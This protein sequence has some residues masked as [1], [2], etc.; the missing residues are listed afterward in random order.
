MLRVFRQASP[1][2]APT[3]RTSSEPEYFSDAVYERAAKLLG[4]EIGVYEPGYR[5]PGLISSIALAFEAQS[6]FK[7]VQEGLAIVWQGYGVYAALAA[8]SSVR[9]RYLVNTYKVPFATDGGPGKLVNDWLL[10]QA[11]QRA[12]GAVAI[13]KSQATA[14][15][16]YCA[17]VLWLPF[18]ADLKWWSPGACDYSVL[19]EHGIP[20]RRFVV[21]VGDVDRDETTTFRALRP[22]RHPIVRVTRD[23]AT[24]RRAQEVIDCLGVERAK[25]VLGVPLW[26]LREIYR[27]AALMVV[28]ARSRVHPAGL[29][30][31]TEGM[32]CAC[33][34][35][36][37]RGHATEGYVQNGVD[38]FVLDEWTETSIGEVVEQVMQSD[39]GEVVGRAGRKCVEDRLNFDRAAR[40]LTAF[41]RKMT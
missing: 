5:A 37:P 16:E 3:K 8:G 25:V 4:V 13:S 29:T 26:V 15:H 30:S 33:P 40:S 36:I 39:I 22:L 10:S 23:P 24:A 35:L 2:A 18:A 21:V 38:A 12:A 6:E 41:L 1:Y 32:S 20:F 9:N 28:P 17:E 31:L 19:A 14:L 7:R 27:G 11:L 34:V